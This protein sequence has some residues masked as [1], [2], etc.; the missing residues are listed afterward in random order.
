MNTAYTTRKNISQGFTLLELLIAIAVFAVMSAMAYG[1][2]NSVI[3]NTT[4]SKIALERIHAVQH[5]LFVMGRDLTQIVPRDIRD[6][7]GNVQPYLS[8]NNNTDYLLEFTRGGHR[9]PAKLKRSNML[10][11]AYKYE[12]NKLNRFFW[13]QLDRVQGMDPY[14][15]ILLDDVTQIQLKYLDETGNWQSQ[16]PPAS[17]TGATTSPRPVAIEL[18]IELKDWG[19]I[20]RIFRVNV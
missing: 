11:I 10:R 14:E 12:D 9:N 6:E 17:N 13:P 16:W 8:T 15:K 2:L 20:T 3:L 7:F 5:A 1:G 19:E 18:R 4:H